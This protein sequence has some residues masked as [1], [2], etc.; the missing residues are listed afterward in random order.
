MATKINDEFRYCKSYD[1]MSEISLN[2]D[3]L[4]IYGSSPEERGTPGE[5]FRKKFPES[6]YLMINE[7]TPDIVTFNENEVNYGVRDKKGISEFIESY[8]VGSI[9]LDVSSLTCR[10]VA[11]L[12][13][14]LVDILKKD[15]SKRIKLIYFEPKHYNIEA[16]KSEGKYH[17]QSEPIEGMK[18]LPGLISIIPDSDNLQVFLIAFLGFEGGR[19]SYILEEL[20]PPK[21]NIIPILGVSGFRLEYPFVAMWGNK[22]ALKESES[23]RQVEYAKANSIAEAFILL[24]S[25]QNKYSSHKLKIAPIGTK[26]HAVAAILFAILNSNV[27]IVYDNPV[28]QKKRT[29][30]FGKILE[31]DLNNLLTYKCS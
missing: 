31:T 12:L 8:L 11:I 5:L 23:W 28:R 7:Y 10:L 22:I 26:P 2:S 25:L 3:T 14:S 19:F 27:E 13:S 15:R 18:P 30:G 21:D 17:D 16:F 24:H 20:T 1:S 6:K 4:Y 29:L 9:Y